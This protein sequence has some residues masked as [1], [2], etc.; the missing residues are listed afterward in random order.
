MVSVISIRM[1]RCLIP[2]LSLV[3][4]RC[5]SSP[6]PLAADWYTDGAEGTLAHHKCE[7]SGHR[8]KAESEGGV[9]RRDACN[10]ALCHAPRPLGRD[11]PFLTLANALR[12][13]AKKCRDYGARTHGN[14]A[15]RGRVCC[16]QQL[17]RAPFTYSLHI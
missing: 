17:F 2:N 9:K 14:H 10:P 5:A 8:E 11:V 6:S 13:P 7:V 4:C 3:K 16:R 12:I 15:I 1:E